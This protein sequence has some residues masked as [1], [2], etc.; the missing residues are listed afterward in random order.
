MKLDIDYRQ[1]RNSTQLDDDSES[2]LRVRLQCRRQL[3]LRPGQPNYSKHFDRHTRVQPYSR[4]PSLRL[5]A[6]EAM[7][8]SRTRAGPKRSTSI[9]GE[10]TIRTVHVD[11]YLCTWRRP[12]RARP[13][14][15]AMK[16]SSPTRTTRPTA[17]RGGA[18]RW[19]RAQPFASGK[20]IRKPGCSTYQ[21]PAAAARTK[22]R[23]GCF[24][25]T[26]PTWSAPP[27]RW[28]AS[29]SHRSTASG[30]TARVVRRCGGL[31]AAS[32]QRS[33]GARRRRL[34]LQPVQGLRSAPG[35]PVR[36]PPTFT[37]TSPRK[38]TTSISGDCQPRIST[39]P[40][41]STRRWPA[42]AGVLDYF[43]DLLPASLRRI[44][45][46]ESQCSRL[47]RAVSA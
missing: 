8:R 44:G 2:G 35:H 45:R 28:P 36:Q 34:R 16:S 14:N 4:Y 7:D 21:Q 33:Q 18:R 15:R 11:E 9:A 12:C 29:S 31:R 27:T 43:D 25:P 22:T 47:A 37:A 41:R 23:A 1:R 32:H 42:C 30:S 13:G 40:V 17:A 20:S 39:R 38:R 24:S 26:A 19:K 46:C 3:C 5:R 6:G 10:L